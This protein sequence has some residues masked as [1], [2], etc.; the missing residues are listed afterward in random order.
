MILDD[1]PE[2]DSIEDEVNAG[3]GDIKTRG[4]IRGASPQST[5]ETSK[6][7][8][9]PPRKSADISGPWYDIEEER[10]VDWPAPEFGPRTP[11]DVSFAPRSDQ[12]KTLP[13][14]SMPALDQSN[15]EC[16]YDITPSSFEE[17]GAHSS[18]QNLN[19]SNNG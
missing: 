4:T 14:L 5:L 19:D 18:N 1:S 8:S 3:A 12:I 15:E 10:Y 16:V 2:E 11:R 13:A 17:L 9:K 6:R 7:A